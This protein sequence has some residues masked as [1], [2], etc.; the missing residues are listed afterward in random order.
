MVHHSAKNETMTDLHLATLAIARP[1]V[2][3]NPVDLEAA[4]HPEMELIRTAPVLNRKS[5]PTSNPNQSLER[6]KWAMVE[7][8]RTPRPRWRE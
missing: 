8:M 7:R 6:C 2:R 4:A 3:P 5:L 1:P